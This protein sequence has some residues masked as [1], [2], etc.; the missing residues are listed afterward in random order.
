MI[1]T[2]TRLS[3]ANGYIDLGMLNEAAEELNAIPE[4][5]HL[6]DEVLSLR[7]RFY[8]ESK[9]WEI[10]AA[11]SKQLATQSSDNTYAWVNWAYA[12]REQNKN[13]EAKE[14]ALQALKLH[15]DEAVLWFNLACYTSLLGEVEEASAHLDKSISLDEIFQKASVDDP[16]L[17]NLWNWLK[18]E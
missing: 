15:P 18:N 7:S 12:L 9:N 3:Y 1:R 4:K 14:I 2:A 8:L 13:A 17:Q 6:Q 5:D 11:V 10:M 16:D